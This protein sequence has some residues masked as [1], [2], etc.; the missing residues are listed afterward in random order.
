MRSSEY[1]KIA[2]HKIIS[3]PLLVMLCTLSTLFCLGGSINSAMAIDTAIKKAKPPEFGT[4]KSDDVNLRRGNGL[5]YAVIAKFTVKGLPVQ[6][7]N[8]KED[9]A[10]IKD[11]DN[12]S[13]WVKSR[14]ISR[15]TRNAI[16][17]KDEV[18]ICRLPTSACNESDPKFK[19]DSKFKKC[20]TKCE[21]IAIA[22]KGAIVNII[23]CNRV[24]CRVRV[25]SNVTGWTTKDNLWGV[26]KYEIL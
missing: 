21:A 24:S 16:V 1:S 22:Q 2:I 9:W 25:K 13:G 7:L 15:K 19:S 18:K 10:H 17:T 8:Q 3:L 12:W 4:L 5:E 6:I 14:F 20:S 11:A 26:G 23:S